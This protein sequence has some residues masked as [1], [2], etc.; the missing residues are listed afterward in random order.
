[1]TIHFINQKNKK[2]SIVVNRSELIVEYNKKGLYGFH[3][4]IQAKK[5]INDASPTTI[6][7]FESEEKRD[8]VLNKIQTAIEAKNKEFI[9]KD[10]LPVD[11]DFSKIT[12]P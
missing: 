3:W 10:A 8:V 11:R 9:V 7:F 12:K 2:D 4:G 5:R 6:G 1:M